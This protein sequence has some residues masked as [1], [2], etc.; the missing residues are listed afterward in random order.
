M[1]LPAF[2]LFASMGLA[3]LEIHQE[4]PTASRSD[5]EEEEDPALKLEEGK[6]CLS[7]DGE[8]GCW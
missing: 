7:K 6:H 3:P 1:Q 2:R 4:M 5:R 8:T